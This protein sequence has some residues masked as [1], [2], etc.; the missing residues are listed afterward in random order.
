MHEPACYSNRLQ[1]K[2]QSH[3]GKN[4]DKAHVVFHRATLRPKTEQVM[5][6]HKSR[7]A[8]AVLGS[9]WQAGR[10]SALSESSVG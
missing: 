6:N 4:M 1:Q 7:V 8:P 5:F 2:V 9:P 3:A 10:A